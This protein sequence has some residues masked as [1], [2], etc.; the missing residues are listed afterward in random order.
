[1]VLCKSSKRTSLPIL[2]NNNNITQTQTNKLK[3]FSYFSQE[4]FRCKMHPNFSVVRYWGPS[5]GQDWN[6]RMEYYP[7]PGERKSPWKCCCC[8]VS[9]STQ[10]LLQRPISEKNWQ[11]ESCSPILLWISALHCHWNWVWL[12]RE[13]NTFIFNLIQRQNIRLSSPLDLGLLILSRWWE[14]PL[15]LS[16]NDSRSF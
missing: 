5:S 3:L 8:W 15:I 11:Q 6:H 4:T 12:S 14:T 16:I 1:M 10:V 2:I 7:E 13:Y 9:P